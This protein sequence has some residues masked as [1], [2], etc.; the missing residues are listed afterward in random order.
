[1]IRIL[2]ILLIGMVTMQAAERKV[3]ES[4]TVP[5][6]NE[7]ALATFGGGCFWCTEALFERVKGVKSAI[8]GYAGGAVDKPTYK[9][10]CSGATGHAEVI[11]VQYNPKEVSYET[12]LEIFFDTHDPTTL[13]QQG[14]DKGT[15]YR[16]IILY[17]DTAQKDVVEKVKA[18]MAKQHRDSITTEI[19]PLK[20]FYPAED[21]HQDYFA[22][23]P[24][25]PYCA[26]VIRPKLQK[27]LKKQ[28]KS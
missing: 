2:L 10:V 27:F 6:T 28:G 18:R 5:G 8:S 1:M 16:S 26:F 9:Q 25:A 22:K 14:N 7:T 11:Q 21:Y 3:N 17:H 24:N 13:N 12:L 4:N 19:V 20:K 15:Q 23:N